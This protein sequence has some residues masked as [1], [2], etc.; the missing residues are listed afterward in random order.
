MVAVVAGVSGESESGPLSHG[1]HTVGI[2][3]ARRAEHRGE[4]RKPR[5]E[6]FPR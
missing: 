6:A 3:R 2:V 1:V 5:V 4:L